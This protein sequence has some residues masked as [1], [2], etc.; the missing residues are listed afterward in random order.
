MPLYALLSSAK[1]NITK[2]KVS[3]F[4]IEKDITIDD[5]NKINHLFNNGSFKINWISSDEKYT[6]DITKLRFS[7]YAGS[8]ATY[9]IL[10]LSYFLPHEITKVLYLDADTIINGNINDLWDISLN[11][12]TIAAV[13]DPYVVV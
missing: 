9:L 11:D 4:I 8:I 2:N 12:K 13:Q 7:G 3:F 10:Y 6:E 5:K 1:S